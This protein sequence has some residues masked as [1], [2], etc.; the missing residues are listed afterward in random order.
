MFSDAFRGQG[1]KLPENPG[2]IKV[3]LNCTLAEFYN[4]SMKTVKY[5]A[6]E[7]QHDG[8]T[9]QIVTRSQQ[10]QVNPGFNEK[11]KL[12][13]K[14]KGHQVAKGAPTNLVVKFK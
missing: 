8:R 6:Q 7:V 11:T 5:E 12:N 10:V 9:T 13:F 14:G 1:A 4:G 3:T 2:N